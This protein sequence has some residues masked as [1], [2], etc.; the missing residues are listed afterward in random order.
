MKAQAIDRY[1]VPGY[2]TQG[3]VLQNHRLIARVIPTPFRRLLETGVSGAIALLVPLSGCDRNPAGAVAA[4]SS[5][6]VEGLDPNDTQTAVQ[7]KTAQKVLLLS[8][9]F[10]HGEGRGS[11]GCV[12]V[13]A[14]VFLTEE[15][16]LDVIKEELSKSG[17]RLENKS[18]GYDTLRMYVETDLVSE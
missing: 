10:P 9:I 17:I 6:Q 2:P 1:P 16:G 15:E 3:E 7:P 13:A 8:P 4:P 18:V 14:P 12:V 11:I 5:Q